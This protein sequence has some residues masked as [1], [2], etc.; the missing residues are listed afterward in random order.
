M[1]VPMPEPGTGNEAP[2][3]PSGARSGP[4]DTPPENVPGHEATYP[5]GSDLVAA[6]PGRFLVA[7]YLCLLG[8]VGVALLIYASKYLGAGSTVFDLPSRDLWVLSLMLV[9]SPLLLAVFQRVPIVFL[10]PPIAL[11]FLLYPLFSPFGLPYDRDVIYNFQF[12]SVLLQSGHWAP[13][14]GVT[15]AAYTY[16]F[17]PGSGV[18]DAEFASV[19]GVPLITT[20]QWSI[21]LLRLLVLPPVVYALGKR[22]YGP[23]VGMLGLVLFLGTPSILFNISVQQEFAVVFLALAFLL[24]T[25]IVLEPSTPPTAVIIAFVL[26]SAFVIV[27]HHLTSYVLL[28]WLGGFLLVAFL[29]AR[30]Q[31]LHWKRVVPLFA[32]YSAIFVLYTSFV[33]LPSF[34]E[35]VAQISPT[36]AGF[37]M[38][39]PSTVT[40]GGAG[41]GQSFPLYQQVWIY[42]AFLLIIV[43]P[44]LGLRRFRRERGWDFASV[45]VVVALVLTLFSIPFLATQFSFLVLRVMEW[46][47]LFLL[48]MAAWWLL[49]RLWPGHSGARALRSLGIR[50]PGI[51]WRKYAGP[52][53]ALAVIVL[54]FTG[55]SLAP[56]SSRDQ[57]APPSQ[58]ENDSPVLI[59]QNDYALGL[60][61]HSHLNGSVLIWGDLYTYSVI[62]GF[63]RFS[64]VWDSYLV[65]NTTTVSEAAWARIV[66]GEYIVVD[67]YM[68]TKTPTFYG[69]SSD[70]PTGPLNIGQVT[71]FSDPTY[72]DRVFGNSSFTIYLVIQLI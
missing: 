65:F 4:T 40:P 57:F 35:Q 36:F 13:G 33:S 50:V 39:T 7:L 15:G 9:A 30:K 1:T 59:D 47:G 54:I 16:S 51:R 45:N 58:I 27:S 72:F 14:A 12:A 19:T 24:L 32:V 20:I 6:R 61:A 38:A 63:G 46:A 69:P 21:P 18:Y 68:T 11:I 41:I 22:L 23:R 2:S 56:Y 60:W 31:A 34:R 44:I 43:L 17:Y 66:V 26:C 10:L 49:Q 71:K 55:G 67:Q 5:L 28:A 3:F 52:V 25:F 8:F 64:M 37:V 42:G 48:P 29:L 70:Q 62:G 53:A